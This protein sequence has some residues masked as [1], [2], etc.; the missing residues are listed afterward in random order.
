MSGFS[1]DKKDEDAARIAERLIAELKAT[2]PRGGDKAV[3]PGQ[4][5]RRQLSKSAN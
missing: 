2:R 4:S 5:A 1:Q 3:S